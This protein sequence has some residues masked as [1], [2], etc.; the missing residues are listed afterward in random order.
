MAERG[1]PKASL[2][3]TEQERDQ[4][5]SWARRRT[6]GQAQALAQRSRIVLGCASGQTNQQVAVSER[7]TPQTRR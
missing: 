4:L 1:R 3:L 5:E 6:S 2:E 7:V